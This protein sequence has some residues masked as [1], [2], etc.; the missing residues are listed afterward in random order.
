[1][2][3]IT[4]G[5]RGGHV[6]WI[7]GYLFLKHPQSLCKSLKKFNKLKLIATSFHAVYECHTVV[8]SHILTLLILNFAQND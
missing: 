1:V 2:T 8:Y 4:G 3:S 6:L 7:D 5:Q